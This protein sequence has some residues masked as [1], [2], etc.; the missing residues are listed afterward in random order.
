MKSC[1]VSDLKEYISNGGKNLIDVRE[2]PEFAGGR[3][4]GAKLLPLGEIERRL[5]EINK[6]EKYFVVCR[7]GRRSGEAQKKLET[8]G[9]SN[10]INV[11]GGFEAWKSAGFQFEKDENA[12]WS[13]ERQ[14][15]F[16]AGLFVVSGVL[17][18]LFVHP[19]LIGISAFVGAGLVFAAVTDTCGMALMLAKMPW[20]RDNSA[21]CE[22]QKA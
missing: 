12:V 1:T 2:F 8:L 11:Q 14:V 6:N 13:L 17:L 15:R 3:I 7:S 10:V 4:K 9:F 20:N 16:T 21:N 19:Y 22:I 5:S 18:S